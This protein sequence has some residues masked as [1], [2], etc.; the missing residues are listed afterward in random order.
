MIKLSSFKHALNGLVETIKHHPN[1]R[2]H[3]VAACFAIIFGRIFDLTREE[4]LI[5][6]VVI[7]LVITTEML[8]TAIESMV[9]LITKEWRKDAKIAKDVA[10]GMV[11]LNSILAL[12]IGLYIFT[13]HILPL[14]A[15]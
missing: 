2:F 5:I 11:L 14:I 3:L 13:P 9:D 1:I 10:A 6:L 8:N 12:I 15:N 4:F 7:V